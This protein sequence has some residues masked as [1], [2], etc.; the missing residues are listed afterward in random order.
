MNLRLAFLLALAPLVVTG[1]QRG[2]ETKGQLTVAMM[3]KN[4]GNPYFVSCHKGAQEAAGP[5]GV[6]LLWDGP[7]ETDPAKQNEVVEA[8]ITRG[9]DVIAVSVE[10][11]EAI[12]TALRKARG[13]GIKVVTWDADAEHDARDLFVNQATPEG[14]ADVL[15][16]QTARILGGKG[17]FA[18]ITA[19]L[20]AANQNEWIKH[21]RELL[22]AK[23]AGL[24]LVDVRPSDD[25]RKRAFDETQTLLKVHPEVKV[26][27]A[28]ASPAIP[29]AA[30]AVKQSGRADV[31]VTGLGLPNASRPYLKDGVLDSVVLWN[32]MDLGYLTI[33]V[34]SALAKGTLKPG[35]TS[36]TAGRLGPLTVAGDN[37]LLG[38]PFTFTKENVDHF[39]F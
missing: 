28:I 30:E 21:I 1:C 34:A 16:E 14:I 35:Q 20:T 24:T 26:V 33:Q 32:T 8:W 25:D 3:P 7:T 15:L 29:G 5:L 12:S 9:V 18:I 4:K 27:M 39:D 37:V 36:F 6:K 13:Q 19:S 38:Q 17:S 31:K 22:G 2:A 23:Y 11:K 10:N